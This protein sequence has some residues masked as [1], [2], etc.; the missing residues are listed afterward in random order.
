VSPVGAAI[1]PT[2]RSVTVGESGSLVLIVT[3]RS[4]APTGRSPVRSVSTLAGLSAA[5]TCPAAP[6]LGASPT[7]GLIQVA[8]AP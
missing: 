3:V 5:P 2:S 1:V 4:T 8:S 7:V 6:W